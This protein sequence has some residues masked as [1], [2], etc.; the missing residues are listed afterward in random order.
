VIL[1][2]HLRHEALDTFYS[3][4]SRQALQ[5][6]ASDPTSL[7]L[8]GDRERDLGARRIA[9]SNER[10]ECNHMWRAILIAELA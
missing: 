7:E 6:S 2:E 4:T 5:E 9:K 1:R 10:A 8:V 3:G